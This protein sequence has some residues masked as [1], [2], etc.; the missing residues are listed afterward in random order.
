MSEAQEYP[1]FVS[2]PDFT[3]EVPGRWSYTPGPGGLPQAEYI[4]GVP[5]KNPPFLV[6]NR[7]AEREANARGWYAAGTYDP[8]AFDEATSDKVDWTYEPQEWPKWSA[9][10]NRSIESPEEETALVRSGALKSPLTRETP[11]TSDASSEDEN[12]ICAP[13]EEISR[14]K[15]KPSGAAY[16]KLRR[17]RAEEEMMRLKSSPKLAA[18]SSRK[19]S[20]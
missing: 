18:L 20:Q 5:A 14:P 11:V 16:R 19:S 6:H 9:E 4:A 10:L 8:E 7:A 12:R 17:Q 2:H 13:L 1:K 3:P 15:K